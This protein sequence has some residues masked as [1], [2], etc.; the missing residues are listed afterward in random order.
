[1]YWKE[2]KERETGNKARRKTHPNRVRVRQSDDE[3]D[4]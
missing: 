4:R 2:R 3:N 1:M